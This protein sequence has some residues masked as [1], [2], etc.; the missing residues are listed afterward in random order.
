MRSCLAF[1]LAVLICRGATAD[2]F[3]L[4]NY[5]ALGG[6]FNYLDPVTF[7]TLAHYSEEDE[8]AIVPALD[9]SKTGGVSEGPLSLSGIYTLNGDL[10]WGSATAFTK[11]SQTSSLYGN[12]FN[13]INLPSCSSGVWTEIHNEGPPVELTLI[14]SY[15]ASHAGGGD[16][17]GI[18]AF[19][20]DTTPVSGNLATIELAQGDK[21]SLSVR[22]GIEIIYRPGEV[23]PSDYDPDA[24][25]EAYGMAIAS[26]FIGPA[27]GTNPG[28]PVK[29]AKGTGVDDGTDPMVPP[30]HIAGI[31]SAYIGVPV[32]ED[33]GYTGFVY[34]G[35]SDTAASD[36]DPVTGYRFG[37][38]GA[39]F[40]ELLL[41]E[42]LPGG[43]SQFDIEFGSQNEHRYRITVGEP[44]SF[45]DIVPEGVD[46]FH[47]TGFEAEGPRDVEADFPSV[48]GMKFTRQAPVKVG[49]GALVERT[50]S[51]PGL[52]IDDIGGLEFLFHAANPGGQLSVK[53]QG[54]EGFSD[55]DLAFVE[56]TVL[57]ATTDGVP[58]F[59]ELVGDDLG[60]A[61]GVDV[62]FHYDET[63]LV[64][65]GIEETQLKMW[66]LHAGVLE[67]ITT[68]LDIDAN[69]ITGSAGGLSGF[70]VG[71][72]KVPE[73]STLALLGVV[74]LMGLA[75]R[76][77]KVME[78][79]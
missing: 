66:H 12:D 8:E 19:I 26:W 35:P 77:R 46:Y 1:I 61:G 14:R 52:D 58:L 25:F 48:L 73:P 56:A 38:A 10:T 5:A 47:F 55:E 54:D 36:G 43:Q 39:N 21:L 79:Q 64:A 49:H 9:W 72:A 59:Y 17:M 4:D 28:D 24:P 76:R 71:I 40:A 34:A 75:F 69:L 37:S 74:V 15:D 33:Y 78:N 45:T 62:T 30:D 13:I 67:D 50:F 57:L 3:Y 7:I 20:N 18:R 65:L 44:F 70:A 63:T 42:P 11:I 41:H 22:V 31:N 53:R 32:A 51:P 29:W 16:Y 60:F 68:S 23:F 2:I 6:G 27:P